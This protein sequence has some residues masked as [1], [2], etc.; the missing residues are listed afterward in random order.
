MYDKQ[1]IDSLVDKIV[2]SDVVSRSVKLIN[3]GRDKMACCP[4]HKEKTPSFHVNDEKGFYHCF[5]CGAHGNVIT[6]I[7]EQEG[8]GF[9]EAIERLADD[10]GIE[11][12]KNNSFTT[13]TQKNIINESES[14]LN[15]NEK[16]C[17]FFQN[18][19]FSAL[20][21]SGL[22]YIMK[23]GL[24][25]DNIKKF[26]IGFAPQ[27]NQLIEFLKKNDFTEKQIENAGLIVHGENGYYDK[28]R[29]RVMFPVLDKK[30]KVIAFTGRV[31]DKDKMPKY[32]NSP[33]TLIYH[34]SNV[35]F[36]YF[37]ARKSIYDNKN[38]IL[39]EGNL[40]AIGLSINGIENVVA[41]MGTAITLKQIE[42]LWVA[43][44]EI[45]VCL[46]GDNAGK[47]ASKRLALLVLPILT[48]TKN[49]KFV[50]LPENQDP[51]DFVK[52]YGKIGFL[53]FINNK[54]NYS[55]LSEFLWK[56]ELNDLN[57]E[58]NNYITPE[59]KSKLETNLKNLINQ[60]KNPLVSK[61]FEDF[62]K[63]QLFL[64]TRYK[65]NKK[66]ANYR[67]TTKI[68]Y[69]RVTSPLNSVEN[70][71]NNIKK[72]EKNIFYL[73][74]NNA[75]FI[76]MIFQQYNIDIFGINYFIEDATNIMDIL[77]NIYETDRINDKEFL[78]KTLEK[79]GFNDY[80]RNNDYY[81]NI[82]NEKK[83]KYLYNLILERNILVLEIEVK[84]LSIKNNNEDRRQI[85][86]KELESLYK[87]K[88]DLES[89]F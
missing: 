83:L 12:K 78:N 89:E 27:N 53:N 47:K 54:E 31:I 64:I 57:I 34:K 72:I 9:K 50:F 79:N 39:V 37:F 63:K 86:L 61:N 35:L 41:P 66:I 20:G 77:L 70:L 36:N 38:V 56:N 74:I 59:Q 24:N 13:K 22:N 8:L 25:I 19:I 40:D 6:F 58:G 14:I 84:E 2:L 4:F 60:I 55:N 81:Y 88:N 30:G 17:Q 43:T 45:I 85:I 87:K 65:S 69:K 68:N 33:E 75:Q 76:D 11:I 48:A 44:D 71:K 23:R 18:C 10:Y 16:A 28:F 42:D 5:G 29:L 1:L 67:D 3:K 52:H 51:D 21:K 32:M 80:I 46:D 82:S 62:Y 7:M 73:L 49:I 15:I 26:R